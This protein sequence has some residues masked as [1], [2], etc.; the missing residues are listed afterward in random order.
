MTNPAPAAG[1]AKLLSFRR[2]GYEAVAVLLG[3]LAAAIGAVI[4]VR[5]LTGLMPPH[6]YGELALAMTISTLGLQV[7]F[8]PLTTSALR[9]FAPA[10]EAG[11]LAG[12]LAAVRKLAAAAAVIVLALAALT[13]V[14]LM[15][16]D[17][18]IW[19][20]LVIASFVFT[21]FLAISQVL[22][23]IQNAAR[24]R[25]I[26]AS[27]SGLGPWL[28][29]LAAAAA[30]HLTATASSAAAMAGYAAA[31]LL[32]VVSQ[33]VFFKRRIAS[34]ATAPP[35]DEKRWRDGLLEYGAPFATWGIFSWAH[36]ASDR[37]ALGAYAATADVGYY[38]VLYQ[39]GFY[40]ILMASSMINAVLAPVLFARAGDAT[41]AARVRD[42]VRLNGRATMA[43][44]GLTAIGVAAAAFLHPLIGRLLLAPEYR[45]VTYLLPWMVLAGGIYAA[46]QIASFAM[47]IGKRSA[48]LRAPKIIT[49]L[50]G[51]GL[52]FAAA[53]WFGIPGVIGASVAFAVIYAVWVSIAARR[54][55][56]H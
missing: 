3:Q 48:A 21:L 8:A 26:A 18:A 1:L 23:G 34:L 46:G 33:Y 47:M 28:R 51:V 49:A 44:F 12:F 56:P 2:I 54:E 35:A 13:V 45:A 4:G 11:D 42:A 39:L 38:A 9:F 10:Q 29:L 40:P 50:I 36:L 7:L 24:H 15:I 6:A 31:S 55:V 5:V 16:A 25:I 30:I 53:K 20:A 17:L 41:D 14:V 27:H 43:V 19:L 32:L 22:D 37:W 52:N